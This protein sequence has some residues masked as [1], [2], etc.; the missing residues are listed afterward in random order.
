MFRWRRR[1]KATTGSPVSVAAAIK[2]PH[3]GP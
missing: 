1:K 2:G 3:C